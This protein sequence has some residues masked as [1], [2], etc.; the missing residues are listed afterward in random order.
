MGSLGGIYW[1]KTWKNSTIRL[2]LEKQ[3]SGEGLGGKTSLTLGFYHSDSGDID[4]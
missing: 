3:F 2:K 1:K 4:A